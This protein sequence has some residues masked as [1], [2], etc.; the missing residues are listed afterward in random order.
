M[1]TD[2][3]AV[4]PTTRTLVSAPSLV[5]DLSWLISVALRP[6]WRPTFPLVSE[7]LVDREELVERVRSFWGDSG[8]EICFTEMQVLAHHAGALGERSPVALW[9]ALEGAVATVPTDLGLESET[10]EDRALFIERLERLKA[11]PELVRSYIDLLRE[12][13]GPVDEMWQ[14]AVPMLEKSG[15]SVVAQL[16]GGRPLGD[17][18]G[19]ACETFQS[20]LGEING[21]LDRGHPLLVVPC[22]FF[23]KSL[24]LEFPGLTLVGSGFE[25][26]DLGS[27]AVTEPLARRLKTVADPTRLALLHYLSA[28]PSTVGDLAVSF[29]LAQ[30]TVSMHVKSLREAGLVRAERQ[31]GRQHLSADPDAV[32]ALLGDLRRVVVHGASNTGSD[33][34]PATVVDATRSADPVMA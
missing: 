33:R 9:A 13:W 6:S 15:H 8:P 7:L 23:G 17:L 1:T 12:V 19:E 22:L 27:R 16:E 28:A 32:E 26:H 5:C 10:P 30:P 2:D 20:M 3:F 14:A 11:S 25:R 21:R 18:V 4:A 31:G 24:Y 29:G 34:I